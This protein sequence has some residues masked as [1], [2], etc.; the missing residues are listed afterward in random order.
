MLPPAIY[1]RKANLHWNLLW[2]LTGY[3]GSQGWE[4]RPLE[5]LSL[6]RSSVQAGV[7]C[8]GLHVLTQSILSPF[9]KWS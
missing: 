3:T 6:H 2:L 7:L 1:P 4:P 8:Y 9:L 5:A